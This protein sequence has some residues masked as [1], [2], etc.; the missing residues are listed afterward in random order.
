[1]PTTEVKKLG[2][3]A[4]GGAL[5]QRLLENCDERGIETFVVGFEG[6]T[7][8]AIIKNR[9]HLWTRPGAAETLCSQAQ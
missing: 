6:Q 8:P 5:P 7:D 9:N 4:G 1:M 2:V 3:V